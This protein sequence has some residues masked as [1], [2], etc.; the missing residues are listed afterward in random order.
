MAEGSAP[1]HRIAEVLET[2][3]VAHQGLTLGD[4][5]RRTGLPKGTVHRIVQN[6]IEV[7]YLSGNGGRAVYTLGPRLLRLLQFSVAPTSLASMAMPVLQSLVEQFGEAAFMTRLAGLEVELITSLMPRR[8]GRAHVDPG[9]IFP[10]NAAATAKSIFAFQ[11]DTVIDQ[12][13][14]APLTQFTPQTQAN[15]DAVRAHL[16]QVRAQGYGVSDEE[17]DAGVLCFACPIRVGKAGV[18]YSVAVV[19][20]K[21]SLVQRHAETEIVAALKVAAERISQILQTGLRQDFNE[22][23]K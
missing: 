14:A 7:G 2:V 3:A 13:L 17:L 22:I 15:R 6:L 20:L 4:L 10:V 12:V 23:L 5:A 8:D 9:Q 19:G 18:L 21:Q 11:P 16:T 1:L